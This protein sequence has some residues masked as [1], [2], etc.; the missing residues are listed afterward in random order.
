MVYVVPFMDQKGRKGSKGLKL[1]Q[2]SHLKAYGEERKQALL[3][4]YQ[5]HRSTQRITYKGRRTRPKRI[6]TIT[7]ERDHGLIE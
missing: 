7:T 5:M 2:A 4:M 1:T 3:I 6:Y